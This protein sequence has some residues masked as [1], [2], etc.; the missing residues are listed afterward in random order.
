[1]PADKLSQLA[2]GV[3]EVPLVLCNQIS[4]VSL[5]CKWR[6]T[7][8][9]VLFDLLENLSR[10]FHLVVLA[11]AEALDVDHWGWIHLLE[12]PVAVGGCKLEVALETLGCDNIFEVLHE[13]LQV[14]N[15]GLQVIVLLL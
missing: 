12:K 4:I 2:L 15:V 3:A 9:L 14:I 1:M 10:C 5:V 7:P 13:I 6:L 11:D 8:F